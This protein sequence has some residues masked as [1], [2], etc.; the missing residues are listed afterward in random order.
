MDYATITVK[1]PKEM[2]AYFSDDYVAESGENLKR[3][4]L[5]LYPYI[6]NNVI[7][8]GRAAEI[9]GIKKLDLIDLYDEMGFPYFDMDIS[10]VRKDIQTFRELKKALA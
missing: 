9:L 5:L 4:A 6:Y 1:V 7:S 10:E 3:N 2:T 8:H